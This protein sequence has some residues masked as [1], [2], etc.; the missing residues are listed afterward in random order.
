MIC[1]ICIEN[2]SELCRLAKEKSSTWLLASFWC[3]NGFVI[4]I[5]FFHLLSVRELVIQQ[6]AS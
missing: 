6:F 3:R 5:A 1:Q 2:A 4:E